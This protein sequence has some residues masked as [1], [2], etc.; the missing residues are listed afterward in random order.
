MLSKHG[1]V[2]SPIETLVPR[3]RKKYS[4][5]AASSKKNQIARLF[6]MI[7]VFIRNC[8]S[9]KLVIID[10]FSSNAFYFSVIIAAFSD[11]F[12]KPYLTIL[13][14]GSLPARLK[15]SPKLSRFL[16]GNSAVNISPS[17]Y[18]EKAF[19]DAGY[20]SIYIPN[21]IEIENYQFKQRDTF[22]PKLLWVR[23][24]HEIYNPELAINILHELLKKYPES[25]LCMVGPDKDGS[26]KKTV[27]LACE[28]KVENHLK[29]MGKLEKSKWIVLSKDYDI[30]LNT[31]NYD[32]HPVSIIESMAL[33]L[34]VVSTNVGGIPF[35]LENEIDA[36]LVSKNSVSEATIAIIR[37]IENREFSILLAKNAREKAEGFA[38]SE[39]KKSWDEIIE[40][41]SNE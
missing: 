38:W 12:S 1:F 41:Y 26:M 19:E 33:G 17:L 10:T 29:I 40:K 14:G 4:I 23:S 20:R 21:F 18:L 25:E 11:L 36:I 27:D 15:S 5:I 39:V 6:H 7:W 32:N 8:Q 16:F 22:K 30:F 28:L 35:L 13:H 2:A 9:S 24:F 3:L 37:L 31:T 34:P